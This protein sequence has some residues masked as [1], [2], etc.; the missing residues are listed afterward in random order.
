MGTDT[1]ENDTDKDGFNDGYEIIT[2][3]TDPL[4]FDI[5]SDFDND[6]MTNAEEMVIGSNPFIK[7]SDFDG[8]SDKNDASP[9]ETDDATAI[10]NK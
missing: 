6:G 10:A 5:D 7:D 8:I 4:K 2:L 3:G 9:L 1:R